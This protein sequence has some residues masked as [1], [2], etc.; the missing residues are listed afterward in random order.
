MGGHFTPYA[1]ASSYFPPRHD[2]GEGAA[3]EAAI[4]AQL[5]HCVRV[6]PQD[7]DT[8]VL[9]GDARTCSEQTASVQHLRGNR[10]ARKCAGGKKRVLLTGSRLRRRVCDQLALPGLPRAA[11][12]SATHTGGFFVGLIQ[13]LPRWLLRGANTETSER[14]L[15]VVAQARTRTPCAA[16][17]CST[18]L[19]LLLGN[20]PPVSVGLAGRLSARAPLVVHPSPLQGCPGR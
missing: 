8:G 2:G 6:L 10:K 18:R 15:A 9:L 5:R 4:A 19:A 20:R 1:A 11:W 16:V 3:L 13:K 14:A 12:I 7:N 17:L